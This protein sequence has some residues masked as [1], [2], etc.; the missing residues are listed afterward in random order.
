[1]AL[2]LY[3]FPIFQL[4]HLVREMDKSKSSCG[5]DLLKATTVLEAILWCGAAWKEVEATTIRKCFV[6][7]GF[8]VETN[9][10]PTVDDNDNGD[11]DVPLAAVKLSM[12]IFGVEYPELADL[13]KDLHTCDT[14]GNNF[15]LPAKLLLEEMVE[16]EMRDNQC[17]SESEEEEVEDTTVCTIAEAADMVNKLKTFALHHGLANVLDSMMKTDDELVMMSVKC[18]TQKKITDFFNA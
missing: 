16:S 5:S 12:D 2:I 11:D 15:D 3:P 17:S 1:M 13:D 14:E 7:A 18:A 4:L 8:G 10:A 9:V 6:K